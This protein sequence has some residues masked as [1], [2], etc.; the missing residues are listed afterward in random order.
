MS[1]LRT[2]ERNFKQITHNYDVLQYFVTSK[3]RTLSS[4]YALNAG[5]SSN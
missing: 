2:F 1:R 3:T 4:N 5:L